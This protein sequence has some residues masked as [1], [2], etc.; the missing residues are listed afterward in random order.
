MDKCTHPHI[1]RISKREVY[2]CLAC[3]DPMRVVP[4]SEMESGSTLT[5]IKIKKPQPTE[6]DN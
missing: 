2:R 4:Y 5:N 3:G 1:F 6:K